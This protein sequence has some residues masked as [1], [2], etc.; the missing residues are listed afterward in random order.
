[1]NAKK[2]AVIGAGFSGLSLAWQLS[3]LGF[4]VQVFEAKERAGGL[5]GTLKKQAMVEK[6][7]HAFLSSAPVEKLFEELDLPMVTAGH[8]SK[9]KWIYRG[10]A[11]KFT[12]NFTES[13]KSF[14]PLIFNRIRNRHWPHSRETVIQWIERNSQS[15]LG[16]YLAAPALQGIYGTQVEDLSASLILGGVFSKELRPARGKLRGSL[17]PRDG[18]QALIERLQEKL[19]EKNVPV[20]LQATADLSKLQG[21]FD[22]VIVACEMSA[23]AHLLQG[24]APELSKN[25]SELP[26][27]SL[28]TATVGYRQSTKRIQ[29]FGCLF[30]K[31]ENFNSLGVLFNTDLFANRGPLESEA[32]IFKGGM[33]DVSDVQILEKIKSDRQ[34]L[35][36]EAFECEFC[37]V[38]RW[39]E[40]LPMYGLQ[41]QSLLESKLFVKA[42]SEL[43]IQALQVVEQGARVSESSSPLYLTG[44]YLGAIGLTKILSYNERLAARIQSDLKV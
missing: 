18:M 17:A 30:P 33:S 11:R 2:L 1:M 28:T 31:K 19:A 16:D 34:R 7:A 22:A 29:G 20:H 10:E 3:K 41:L 4:Q 43:R 25:L 42:P 44:N 38:I 8:R 39:P 6:A 12:L 21:E 27:V 14:G 5:I 15:V 40:T 32:W 37:E 13:L 35:V 26:K 36:D 9:T 24:V 23:A